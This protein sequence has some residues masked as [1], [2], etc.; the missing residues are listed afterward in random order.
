MGGLH[1]S[2]LRARSRHTQES[3]KVVGAF[4]INPNA[5]DTYEHNFGVRPCANSL[6]AVPPAKFD[7]L[8]ANLWLMSPPCQPF[9]RQGHQKDVNDGR[10]QSFLRLIDIL[11]E[12]KNKPDHLLVENVVGFEVSEVRKALLRRYARTGTLVGSLFCRQGCSACL[13]RGRGT[14]ASRNESGCG[15]R[16]SV[17]RMEDNAELLT[18]KSPE[19]KWMTVT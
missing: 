11:P 19:M 14:F 9:T 2:L 10:S 15:G 5:N 13:I 1:Y 6:Y 18:Q 8:N 17:T 3:T 16:K 7:K 4:D 12:L